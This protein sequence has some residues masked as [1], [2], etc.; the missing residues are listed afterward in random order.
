M[1]LSFTGLFAVT[2]RG[3]AIPMIN[4]KDGK[5]KS[6]GVSPSH[7]ACCIKDGALSPPEFAKTIPKTVNPRWKSKE[8]SLDV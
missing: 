2:A 8:F 1:F 5:I 6:T 7:S 3:T 4:M